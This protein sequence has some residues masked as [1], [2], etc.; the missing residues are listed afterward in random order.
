MGQVPCPSRRL[1]ET[2]FPARDGRL[3]CRWQQQA[4][5]LMF[6]ELAGGATKANEQPPL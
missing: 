3:R 5:R 2:P 4:I 6:C 1:P